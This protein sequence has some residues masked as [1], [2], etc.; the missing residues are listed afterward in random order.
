[1]V[2]G[3]VANLKGPKGDKGDAGAQ[4]AT[5]AAGSTTIAGITGL[6]GALDEK[7]PK[8]VSATNEATLDGSEQI[9]VWRAGFL[10]TTVAK[11]CAWIVGQANIWTATQTFT[12]VLAKGYV[13]VQV[14]SYP[15]SGAGIELAGPQ[16]SN[17]PVIQSFDRNTGSW[18]PLRYQ[19]L[20]H[21]FPNGPVEVSNGVKFGELSPTIKCKVV[22]GTISATAGAA[23]TIAHGLPSGDAI[24]GVMAAASW[25]PPNQGWVNPGYSA[26]MGNGEFGVIWNSTTISVRTTAASSSVLGRTVRLL[27][28]YQG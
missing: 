19:A 13:A 27:V 3:K 5:G 26:S 12:S 6:Q 21:R 20:V 22:T 23:T 25:D 28:F 24:L 4:G 11:I 14:E 8:D 10:K 2:W 18:L 16:G 1:M 7:T 17:G 15:S 9:P